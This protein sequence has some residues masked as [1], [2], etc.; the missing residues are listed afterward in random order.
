[1]MAREADI[2]QMLGLDDSYGGAFRVI[3]DEASREIAEQVHECH[4]L[5]VA[6]LTPVS[7]DAA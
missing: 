5:W 1:M 6:L 3:E 4:V 2:V 7:F